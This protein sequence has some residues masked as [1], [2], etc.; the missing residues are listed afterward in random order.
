M[1]G[2]AG[3]FRFKNRV[4]FQ[5]LKKMTDRI[6]HR[7]PDAEGHWINS[8][9][10][11][12][13][14]H[15]RLSIIDLSSDA[16]QPMH[17]QDGRFAIVFNGEIYNYLELK[18]NLET[19]GIKFYSQSD[20][21]VLLQLYAK[22]GEAC[23]DKLDG[24]F[25]F[26]I[27]DEHKKELFCA[28]DRFG[29]KPFYYFHDEKNM[30]S[31]AS[32]MKAIFELKE[33]PKIVNQRF[34]YNFFNNI[35]AVSNP[36][37][38]SETLYNKIKKLPAA[39][40]IK[41]GADGRLLCCKKYWDI[42]W[43][44]NQNS[45][46][47][48]DAIEEFRNLFVESV[49]RRLRSDV[50]VGTS[51]SGG[52]DSS[53]IVCLIDK[54]KNTGFIQK[55]FSARFK[56]FAKDE[57]FFMNL[58][59]D[60]TKVDPYF[61][62]P[63]EN[64]FIENFEELCFHQEEPFGSS[65][66]FAQWEVMKLTKENNV[67]VLL[68][69]QGAD[70][71]LAGYRGYY[72]TYLGELFNAKSKLYKNELETYR[73]RYDPDFFGYLNK[74]SPYV[75]ASYAKSK[76]LSLFRKEVPNTSRF[77]SK[78]FSD[79]FNQNDLFRS[80]EFKT[81]NEQ[82]YISTMGGIGLENLLRYADRNSMAFSREVRLPFLSHEL[83]EFI[84]S[85]PPGLKIKNGWSKYILRASFENLLPPEITWRK[86]KIG[87]EP[88]QK[89][90]LSTKTVSEYAEDCRQKLLHER[91]IDKTAVLDHESLWQVM[92]VSQYV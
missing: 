31:F 23:L 35:Y 78:D 86:D 19:E 9:G 59:I 42:D 41:I 16:S 64:K 27:W 84:F 1:C 22:M 29:E 4:E 68:D 18:K 44:K 49:V 53:T 10:N 14:G 48:K 45:I 24:M 36:R 75:M 63:D 61:T 88:P 52:L 46:K 60:R 25:A 87:Y 62:W 91:I 39:H 82:L 3:I 33:V 80:P 65:S 7:G 47:E 21:E 56:N 50:P 54:I 69:G 76:M 5:E 13:L 72:K 89:D 43:E 26:A 79:S 8:A 57:G 11:L 38:P 51:L 6:L 28:R 58:V 90:W 34:L 55:T 32:E 17:S 70:E 73:E 40:F 2:I 74:K 71:I 12:G 85:L 77:L 37:E 66:I 20:T 67:T 92:V 83:V 15:R 81:L 30:F